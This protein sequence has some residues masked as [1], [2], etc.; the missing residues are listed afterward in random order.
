MALNRTTDGARNVFRFEIYTSIA[1]EHRV[2]ETDIQMS[3]LTYEA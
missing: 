1:V 2:R 3:D